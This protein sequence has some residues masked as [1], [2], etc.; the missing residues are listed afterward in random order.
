MLILLAAAMTAAMMTA[1]FIMLHLE[2]ASPAEKTSR[3]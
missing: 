2:S 3:F 1:T